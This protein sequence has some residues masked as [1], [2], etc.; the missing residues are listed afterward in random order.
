[1]KKQLLKERFQEL[2]GIK[3]LHEAYAC[4]EVVAVGC[5]GQGSTATLPCLT[6]DGAVPTPNDIG[7]VIDI[8]ALSSGQPNYYTVREVNAPTSTTIDD[9]PEITAGCSTPAAGCPTCDPTQWPNMQTWINHW[10]NNSAFTPP[11]GV[12]MPCQHICN[13]IQVWE[14]KCLNVGPEH[15]IQLACKIQEGYNQSQI[16]GCNC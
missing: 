16:H 10:T 7:K 8:G 6:I 11:M 2:A 4:M 15:Q 3:P 12:N 5:I 13:R 9:R 1:M 14:D